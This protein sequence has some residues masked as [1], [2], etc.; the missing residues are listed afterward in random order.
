MNND[1]IS[2]EALKKHKV[3]SEERHEYVVPVYNIDNAP[4]VGERLTGEWVMEENNK[5]YPDGRAT[6]S[7][8]GYKMD[9]KRWEWLPAVRW[10]LKPN[11]CPECGARMKGGAEE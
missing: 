6:C 10:Y 5:D 4:T 1:L 11:Y 2:R 8:C 3:Y 7:H 9:V